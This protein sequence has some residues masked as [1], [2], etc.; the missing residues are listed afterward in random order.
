LP[1]GLTSLNLSGNALSDLDEDSIKIICDNII[2]ISNDS[3]INVYLA[4]NDISEYKQN[5]W[6]RSVNF[7]VNLIFFVV[8]ITSKITTESWLRLYKPEKNISPLLDDD[9]DKV[10]VGCSK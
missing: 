5:I 9:N 3:N 8:A 6:R 10:N 7:A 2:R 4:K 1:K